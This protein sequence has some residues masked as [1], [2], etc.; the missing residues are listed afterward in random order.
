MN[1][2]ELTR[3]DAI[4]PVDIETT[5][6]LVRE[7]LRLRTLVRNAYKEGFETGRDQAATDN[8]WNDDPW[9][10]DSQTRKAIVRQRP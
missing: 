10:R 6:L 1:I 8:A 5:G 7:V 3:P 2:D 9:W 4:V